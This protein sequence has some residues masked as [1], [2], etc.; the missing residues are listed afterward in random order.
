MGKRLRVKLCDMRNMRDTVE[1][2]ALTMPPEKRS[3][4]RDVR[5]AVSVMFG[6]IV[7][8]G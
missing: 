3:V 1:T 4:W 7:F 6:G 5:R 8:W 2:S